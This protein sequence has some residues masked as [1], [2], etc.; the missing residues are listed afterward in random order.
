MSKQ[1]WLI[2]VIFTFFCS[3]WIMLHKYCMKNNKLIQNIETFI[4]EEKQ[5]YVVN[6]ENPQKS[7]YPKDI[8]KQKVDESG[9]IAH[10]SH[11][12]SSPECCPSTYSTDRGC[13]CM[14]DKQKENIINRGSNNVG[15]DMYS[16]NSGLYQDI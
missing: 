1:V 10:L 13:I 7:K 11:N 12:I 8:Q 6:Y 9:N 2:I 14:E 3:T 5:K 4:S 16:E 15:K